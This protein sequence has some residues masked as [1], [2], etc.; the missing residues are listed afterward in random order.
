[1]LAEEAHPLENLDRSAAQE[2]LSKA[3]SEF[4]SASNEQV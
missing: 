2:A 3:Q 4:N 1:V